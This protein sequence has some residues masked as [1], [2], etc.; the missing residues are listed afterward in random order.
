M[1]VTLEQRACI[2]Q[3]KEYLMAQMPHPDA[4]RMLEAHRLCDAVIGNLEYLEQRTHLLRRLAPGGD[5]ARFRKQLSWFGGL[6]PS[7]S[8]DPGNWYWGVLMWI[9]LQQLDNTPLKGELASL[10]YLNDEHK[11]DY[12]EAILGIVRF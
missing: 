1:E 3:Y 12:W 9:F 10:Q 4:L 2:R 11:G 5:M 6:N 7:H 8:H